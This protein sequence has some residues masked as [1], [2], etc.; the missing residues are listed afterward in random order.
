MA[1]FTSFEREQENAQDQLNE[2]FK[3]VSTKQELESLK[4]TIIKDFQSKTLGVLWQ[5]NRWMVG[6]HVVTPSKKLSDC[7]SGW[8]LLWQPFKDGTVDNSGLNYTIIPKQHVTIASGSGVVCPIKAYNGTDKTGKYVYITD[9][10]IKGNDLNGVSPRD[11]LSLTAV[12][13]Y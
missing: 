12:L 4:N 5:G 11:E 10:N 7:A 8:I 6:S 2:N 13:E 1:L 3:Q 9:N